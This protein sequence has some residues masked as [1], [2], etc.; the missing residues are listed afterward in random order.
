VVGGAVIQAAVALFLLAAS[1]AEAL[2][3]GWP[4]LYDVTDVAADDVLNVREAPDADAPIVGSLAPD[5]VIEVIL[6]SEDGRWGMVNINEGPGWASLR[7]L[8]RRPDQTDETYPEITSCWGTEPFWH[9]DRRDG[10]I[11]Y[12]I[13]AT[14]E[15]DLTETILWERPTINHRHRYAFRTENTV[16][17]IS[18]QYCNDG[19]SGI[20]TGIEINFILL[21]KDIHLQG[22]C[23]IQPPAE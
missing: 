17:V 1:P 3:D 21:D 11:I 12:D 15:Y 22:C 19:M 2:V 23:T 7:Y 9:L 8:H 18:R 5:S 14:D 10:Q 13:M 16:A 20:E 4:A 6:V